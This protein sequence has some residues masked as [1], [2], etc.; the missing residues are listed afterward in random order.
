MSKQKKHDS[1]ER[2]QGPEV[3]GAD[4]PEAADSAGEAADIAGQPAER[5]GGASAELG[6]AREALAV[7]EK[8]VN[9][10]ATKIA[11]L[12]AEVSS[13]KDQ[14]LRKLADYENF[15]KRMFR[16]KEDAVK[17]ANSQ[18]LG[19]LVNVVDD[20]DRAVQSS[21]LSKDFSSLHDG[22]DMIRKGLLGLLE[23]KYGLQRFDSVGVAFDPNLHEAVMSDSGECAE[24][25]VVEEFIKGYKLRD[26]VLRS[27]KVK[28]RM[29]LPDGAANEE[30]TSETKA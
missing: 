25:Y 9:E 8:S 12:E 21:E 18:I 24:P 3:T 16:E 17:F 22:V 19:D 13:L 1:E 29:P 6:A 4:R 30:T 20:F 28:V 15:R 2:I 26:R 10:G 11:D 27:A 14:Y 23:S 5:A 7:A